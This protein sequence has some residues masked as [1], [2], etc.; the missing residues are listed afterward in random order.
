[1]FDEDITSTTNTSSSTNH[2]SDQELS[3]FRAFRE[4]KI[5]AAGLAEGRAAANSAHLAN[6]A[7]A[8][9]EALAKLTGKNLGLKDCFGN[10]STDRGRGTLIN[11]YRSG[12]GSKA[13]TYSRLRRMAAAQN[14]VK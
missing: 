14:L 1:M 12:V 3:E 4:S 11:L 13:Q 9:A 10:S 2:I 6:E 8:D 7:A 5:R